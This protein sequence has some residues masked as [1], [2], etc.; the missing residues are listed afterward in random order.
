MKVSE[1]FYSIQGE[2][3]NTGIPMTFV[4]LAGCNLRCGFC[5]TPYA[6]EDGTEMS[7]EEIVAEVKN[8]GAAWVCLT[9]GEPFLQE[10]ERLTDLLKREGFSI[11]IETNGTI[12]QAVRCDWLV[13][14]PKPEEPPVATMLER[15]DEIKIVIDSDEALD[16]ASKYGRWGRYRSVQ[17]DGNRE[18]MMELCARFV[19]SNPEWRLSVQMHKLI[20]VR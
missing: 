16:E 14:S 20:G 19:K 6:F 17:P 8:A 18:E 15:A 5:D 1:V 3:V 12:H 9:G 2:G 7:E 10:L 4:R 11:H 13:V